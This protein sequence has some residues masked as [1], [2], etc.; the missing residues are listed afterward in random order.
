MP[1]A[2]LQVKLV[3]SIIYNSCVAPVPSQIVKFDHD[4]MLLLP[5]GRSM[6]GRGILSAALLPRAQVV[7]GCGTG[8]PQQETLDE[9]E[10]RACPGEGDK[11]R[12]EHIAQ[13]SLFLGSGARI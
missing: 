12:A 8:G 9:R 7:D 1:R 3:H 10:A 5:N 6:L 13:P 11:K 4:A 2:V